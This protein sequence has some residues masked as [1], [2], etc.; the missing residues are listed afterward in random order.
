[1]TIARVF[2]I[3]CLLM[4]AFA[5]QRAYWLDL[6]PSPSGAT[7]G[8]V[9]LYGPNR[10][11]YVDIQ[12]PTLTGSWVF[13]PP[14]AQ[15][16]STGLCIKSATSAGATE[17]GACGGVSQ[18]YAT[19]QS[20]GSALTQ[21]SVL[22]FISGTGATVTAVDNAG[23]TRTDVTISADT[24]EMLT[25]RRG[26]KRSDNICSD[27]GGDDT[28]GVCTL[29]Y[30]LDAYEE[31]TCFML[32]VSTANT[33]PATVDFGLGAKQIL[34]A[35]AGALADGAV[36]ARPALN[37]MCYAPTADSGNGA[38]L[39][40]G[41]GSVTDSRWVTYMAAGSVVGT[42]DNAPGAG[43]YYTY[44]VGQSINGASSG[45][46]AVHMRYNQSDYAEIRF[47]LPDTWTGTIGFKA[48]W[49]LR[50]DNS[51]TGTGR[52]DYQMACIT[53]GT[54]S[55]ASA[56]SYSTATQVAFNFTGTTY[57][58]GQL[59]TPVLTLGSGCAAGDIA[60][61]RMT[62]PTTGTS[63]DMTSLMWFSIQVPSTL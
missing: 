13:K 53:S 24:S 34:T 23:S 60:V 18:A 62:R 17:W 30:P 10:T 42:A 22:N 3:L 5:Q 27:L 19:L 36:A 50:V 4:P 45:F 37:E 1:M 7:P 38:F 59:D 32:A 33:G 51:G 20:S 49:T 2:A 21:R 29:E 28:Y 43:W 16:G 9:R 6:I 46:R 47:R 58:T 61:I 56:L 39:L 63:N 26:Q 11:Y 15:P 35:S 44:Q 25:R 8:R 54:D 55:L 52:H 40:R 41:G 31:G 12:A 48:Y 57:N 14:V